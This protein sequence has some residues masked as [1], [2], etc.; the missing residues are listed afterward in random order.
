MYS[1]MA[2]ESYVQTRIRLYQRLKTKPST[3]IPAD[4]KSLSEDIKRA[5]LQS[6]VLL[7][8]LNANVRRIDPQICGWTHNEK[9]SRFTP[10]WF[11]G[12]QLPP[13][14]IRSS[15]QKKKVTNDGND[16]DRESESEAEVPPSTK[17]PKRTPRRPDATSFQN[18]FADSEVSIILGPVEYDSEWEEDFTI[19]GEEKSDS[20]D[21]DFMP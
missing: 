7:R 9:L 13:S 18:Y 14:L 16:A 10:I 6:Y 21:S 11:K 5:N 2:K 20:S 19:S 15:R 3:A 17:R 8:S 1:G 4:P 12:N